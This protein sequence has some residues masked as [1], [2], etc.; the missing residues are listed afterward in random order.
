MTFTVPKS[1]LAQV[2]EVE[3]NNFRSRPTHR[4]PVPVGSLVVSL[5]GG[6]IL[7][8]ANHGDTLFTGRLNLS[9]AWMV[10]LTYLMSLM[11]VVLSGGLR[12]PGVEKW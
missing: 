4:W 3:P 9:L 8:L 7:T 12:R 1:R 2:K 5:V 6:T 11:V 10:P